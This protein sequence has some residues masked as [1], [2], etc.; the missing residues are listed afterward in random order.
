MK[1]FYYYSACVMSWIV[2]VLVLAFFYVIFTGVNTSIG[3]W[4]YA[5]GT[6]C[7]QPSI[8]MIA[9]GTSL[10]LRKVLFSSIMKEEKEFSRTSPIV[11]IVIGLAWLI[12]STVSQIKIKQMQQEVYDK[13]Y[14][15]TSMTY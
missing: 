15:P 13:Y 9:L 8:W 12:F 3:G 10:L 1:D 14:N 6:G 7:G 2:T 11:L 4:S 5:L